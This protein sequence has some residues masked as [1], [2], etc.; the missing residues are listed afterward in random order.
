M[1]VEGQERDEHEVCDL[2]EDPRKPLVVEKY[3]DLGRCRQQPP[4]LKEE[5]KDTVDDHERYGPSE[6]GKLSRGPMMMPPKT[7][8]KR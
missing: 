2:G 5:F 6:L 8:K 7:E 1:N 4:E 3:R